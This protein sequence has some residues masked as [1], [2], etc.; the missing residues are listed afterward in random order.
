MELLILTLATLLGTL[1]ALEAK[2]WLP[3]VGR[4]LIAGTTRHF[5]DGIDVAT[6]ERW[7]REIEADFETFGDRP[8]GG[9]LF[10]LRVRL[11]GGRDLAAELALAEKIEEAEDSTEPSISPA[12][13]N[14]AAAVNDEFIDGILGY[15]DFFGSMPA[16]RMETA[17]QLLRTPFSE[18]F[19]DS[20]ADATLEVIAAKLASDPA[21][22]A[23]RV[24]SP[25]VT[26]EG[27]RAF[28]EV[29]RRAA[30][31]QS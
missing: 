8:L 29:V 19:G 12:L 2:A 18:V 17:A 7:L 24:G 4:W 11:K 5:P 9:L 3:Y 14:F 6:R 27:V 1:L 25:A 13:P 28:A 23:T 21:G 20:W 16:D 22:H 31:S 30:R 26:A 10:A 15:F